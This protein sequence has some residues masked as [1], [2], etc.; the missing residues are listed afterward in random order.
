M[1]ITFGA[2]GMNGTVEHVAAVGD[3]ALTITTLPG[4]ASTRE[5][6]DGLRCWSEEPING[7]RILSGAEAEQSRIE[8]AWNVE[9]RWRA[10]FPHIEAR[11]ERDV[12]GAL[13]ECLMMTPARGEGDRKSDGVGGV[14]GVGTWTNCYDAATHLLTL[15]RVVQAGPQGDVPCTTRLADWRRVEDT[16]IPYSLEFESGPLTFSGRVTLVELD[17]PVD[18]KAFLLPSIHPGQPPA[19][20]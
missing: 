15:E 7:L 3:R 11:N 20:R 9:L 8:A 14:A 2:L 10:L 12:N 17:G 18:A 1:D 13:L 6:C 19:A 16:E 5:G 4:L